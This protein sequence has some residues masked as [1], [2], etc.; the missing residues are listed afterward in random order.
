MPAED[1]EEKQRPRRFFTSIMSGEPIPGR[2]F[3]RGKKL[4][5][6]EFTLDE[7]RTDTDGNVVEG[8]GSGSVREGV[9]TEY[10]TYKRRWFGLVQ[11]TLMNIIVS[12]DVSQRLGDSWNSSLV[13][14][15]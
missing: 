7:R 11:L 3:W 4:G 14:S 9:T 6:R 13:A 5:S 2:R 8:E 15:R 1:S 10:R 12:W